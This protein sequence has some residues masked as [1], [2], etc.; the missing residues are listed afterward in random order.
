MPKADEVKALTG[1][2]EKLELVPYGSTELRVT[3]FPIV[4]NQIIDK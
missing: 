2:T 4:K 1:K 3:V